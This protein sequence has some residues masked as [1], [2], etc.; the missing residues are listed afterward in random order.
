VRNRYII[1][2]TGELDKV[3]N[4]QR[5]WKSIGAVGFTLGI[6]VGG[7]VWVIMYSLFDL[8]TSIGFINGLIS[9]VV[10]GTISAFALI[11]GILG[12]KEVFVIPFSMGL[13]T[14]VGICVGISM[15]LTT[16]ISYLSAFSAGTTS[17]LISGVLIGS[18]LWFSIQK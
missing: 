13:G 17:G 12:E 3:M 15:A 6:V 8:S 4:P 11:R 10:V 16:D 5:T 7:L 1:N 14:L 9:G 18:S 2:R